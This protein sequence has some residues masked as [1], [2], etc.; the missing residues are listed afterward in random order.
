MKPSEKK[1]V[2]LGAGPTGIGAAWR[3]REL[4]HENWLLLEQNDHAGGLA[5]S[6]VDAAGFTWDVGGHVQ[7]S[8]YDYFDRAM[9]AALPASDWI[10]HE[11][12]SWIW[13]RRRFIPY[14]LQY[15]IGL[16]P[17]E[18][19]EECLRGLEACSRGPRQW[20]NFAEWIDAT[21]GAGLRRVFMEP[22]NW[23]AW[24]WPLEQMGA[25]WVG[26]RV[27]VPSLERIRRNIATGEPDRSWGPNNRFRFPLRGGTGSIWR[28]L[29]AQLP[30]ERLRFSTAATA[31][32]A[33][34]RV[35]R[36]ENG[37][38]EAYDALISSIPLGRLLKMAG[39]AR[40]AGAERLAFS[41]CNIFGVGLA[42]AP[43]ETLR[44]KCWMYFPEDDNPFYRVTVF[45]N[46]SPHNAPGE[47]FW[48]LMAEVSESPH[49]PVDH[50]TLPEAVIDGLIA[51][52]LIRR[53]DKI[54]S[55]W[56]HRASPGYPTPFLHRERVID[57]A[58]DELLKRGIYSRG[59]FGAW[60]YEVGN[61]DHAFM[62]GVE[63][64]DHA[65]LGTPELTVRNPDLVNTRRTR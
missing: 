3:L 45:S 30:G 23:K 55:T 12:E 7:F 50:A 39:M 11:R 44:T 24:A 21:F 9:D 65:L 4:D 17:R 35:V 8:H 32:D 27:A 59:R 63:A 14:P 25:D 49:K 13:M 10:H 15:N 29:A 46:Y 40:A 33:E 38:E 60:K 37:R 51:T 56:T 18:E 64:V 6:F 58:L 54:V 52:G 43:P 22:Y 26:D 19:M 47:G 16:L 62:Q 2:I 20:N 34:R 42:G 36:F 48:S 57:A 61:Q 31:V 1:I 41:S 5:S 53:E 28:S